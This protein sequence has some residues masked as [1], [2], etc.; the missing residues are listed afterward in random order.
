[1]TQAPRTVRA[2]V[3]GGGIMGVSALY[4]ATGEARYLERLNLLADTILGRMGVDGCYDAETMID[5]GI[6]A[7][8][9]LAKRPITWL[10][11][12]S[13]AKFFG[14]RS[15]EVVDNVL[16]LLSRALIVEH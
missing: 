14:L 1:M 10:R 15:R 8:R 13:D 7:T 5:K 16:K 9:Q 6:A 12:E 4:Q 11:S 3:I 2:A